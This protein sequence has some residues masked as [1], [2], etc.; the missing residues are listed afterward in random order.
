LDRQ[1][2]FDLGLHHGYD[3]EYYLNKGFKVIALEANPAMI[4]R[5]RKNR[6]LAAAEE[7]GRLGMVPMALWHRGG[8]S[9]SFYLNAQKDDWSSIEKKWA[10]KEKHESQ[11]I[12]VATISLQEMVEK[13]GVPYYIK[14]DL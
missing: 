14:C 6:V 10:E 1:L 8:E 5:A 9:I 11:E 2:I 3:A 4:R 12:K 7:E 13:L